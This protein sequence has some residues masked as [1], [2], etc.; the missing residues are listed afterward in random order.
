[1]TKVLSFT[2]IGY[3]FTVTVN[4]KSEKLIFCFKGLNINKPAFFV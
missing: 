2:A 4:K 1:M 3:F